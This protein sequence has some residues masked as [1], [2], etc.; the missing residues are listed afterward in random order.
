MDEKDWLYVADM[1]PPLGDVCTL[2]PVVP[3]LLLP[4]GST[5]I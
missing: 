2:T 5:W 4:T 3:V 1:F